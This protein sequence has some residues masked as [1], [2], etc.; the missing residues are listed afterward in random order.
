MLN[1]L[2]DVIVFLMTII[3]RI[4]WLLIQLAIS[5]PTACIIIIIV[6]FIINKSNK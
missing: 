2:E 1:F 3:I 4:G 5:F 6:L